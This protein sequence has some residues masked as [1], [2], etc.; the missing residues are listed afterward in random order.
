MDGPGFACGSPGRCIE[1]RFV[2]LFSD[3]AQTGEIIALVCG[4]GRA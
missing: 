1:A 3:T 4:S 2:Y